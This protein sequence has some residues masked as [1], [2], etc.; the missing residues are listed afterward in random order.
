M[1][2]RWNDVVDHFPK[3]SRVI[4]I[5][6]SFLICMMFFSFNESFFH[7]IAGD[8]IF[9]PVKFIARLE[10]TTMDTVSYFYKILDLFGD[11]WAWAALNLDCLYRSVC[12]KYLAKS[13]IKWINE[14]H[15]LPWKSSTLPLCLSKVGGDPS[16]TGD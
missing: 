14:F 15:Q 13:I 2:F 3:G 6:L 4:H 9:C 5:I 10:E 7:T 12:I 8:F 16:P 11:K 1:C